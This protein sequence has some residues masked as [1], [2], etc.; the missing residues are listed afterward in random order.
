MQVMVF[1]KIYNIYKIHIPLKR[2]LVESL[3]YT[4]KW[5]IQHGVTPIE[6][7]AQVRLYWWRY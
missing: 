7:S 3:E 4:D 2:K 1:L 5:F 6:G